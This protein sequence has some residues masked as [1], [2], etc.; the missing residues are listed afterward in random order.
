MLGFLVNLL[1]LRGHQFRAHFTKTD[2]VMI[3]PTR[4]QSVRVGLLGLALVCFGSN[5]RLYGGNIVVDGGFE[6]ADPNGAPGAT[7]YFMAGES[8]DGGNWIVGPNSEVGVDTQNNYVF[9]G[10]KSVFL[11]GRRAGPDS[12]TQ[13]LTTVVGQT[14]TMSFYGNA[15]TPNTFSVTFGDPGDRL[16]DQH[17]AEW[18]SQFYMAGQFALL[19]LLFRHGDGDLYQY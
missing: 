19:H 7:N 6:A 18:I 4:L 12:L 3:Q 10:N 5:A 11:D 2:H 8:I 1:Y 16:A 13:T 15:D 9:A 14:Y 17:R